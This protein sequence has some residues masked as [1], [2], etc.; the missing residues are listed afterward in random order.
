MNTKISWAAFGW[1]THT[2]S[3][4]TWMFNPR[5]FSMKETEFGEEERWGWNKMDFILDSSSEMQQ[6]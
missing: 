4:P 1:G 3:D 2:R 5:V 6:V